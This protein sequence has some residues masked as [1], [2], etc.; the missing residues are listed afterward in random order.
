MFILTTISDLIQIAPEDFEKK[1]KEAIEDNINQKYANKVVQQVGLCICLWDLYKTSEGLI[2]HTTGIV[3]VNVEFRLVV[4]RPFKGEILLGKISSASQHGIKIR[5]DFFDDIFV[6]PHL[7]FGGSYFDHTEQTWVWQ[8]DG[9]LF[10]FDKNEAVRFRVENE[11]WNDQSPIAP[12]G[13]AAERELEVRKSPYGIEASM[14]AA[15]LGPT[16]WW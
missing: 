16:M 3:H 12:L 4:F 5:L 8:S 10:Y 7:L 14:S 1:S 15:G 13:T 6:P 2:G 11:R 9:E